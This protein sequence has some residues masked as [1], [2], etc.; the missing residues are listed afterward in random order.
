MITPRAIKASN[1]S[2][3]IF[4]TERIV[5][6]TGCLFEFDSIARVFKFIFLVVISYDFLW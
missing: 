3:L 1:T 5:F 2:K 4:N 6:N